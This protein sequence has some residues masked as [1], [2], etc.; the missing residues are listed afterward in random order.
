MSCLGPLI[1]TQSTA[2]Q[3]PPWASSGGT[4]SAVLS[5][6][7]TAYITLVHSTLEYAASIWDPHLAKDCDLLEKLQR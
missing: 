5:N 4:F 6:L 1:Y 7:E 3:T 2:V